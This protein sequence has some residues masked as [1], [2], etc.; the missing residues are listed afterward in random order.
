MT[1]PVEYIVIEFP[2]NQFNGDV[3][4]ALAELIENGTVR[5]IDLLFVTKDA[6]GAVGWFELG[7][8]DSEVA[9]AFELL[10]GEIGGLVS[11]EDAQEVAA[12]LSENSSAAILVW[13]NTWAERF[14]Q[15]VVG[16]EGPGGGPRAHLRPR[17]WPWPWPPSKKPETDP[18]G[19][20]EIDE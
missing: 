3:V 5:L 18:D 1:T 16:L 19:P 8:L 9:Q 4:P 11:E 12:N 2:G 10:E 14:A 17:W 13:E 6:S 15:A 7:D 20:P